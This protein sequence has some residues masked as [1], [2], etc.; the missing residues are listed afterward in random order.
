MNEVQ[1]AEAI[2]ELTAPFFEKGFSFE[3]FHQKGGDSSCVYVFRYKKGKDYFDW[4]E[5]S[6]GNE[7][8]IVVYV[9]GEFRFPSLKKLY[10]KKYRAFAIKHLFK[11]ATLANR[12]ALTASVLLAELTSDK[13]DFFG[14]KL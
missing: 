5:V 8:N 1:S 4:R 3:Y 6:G 14:I 7:I 13:P 9:N 12:R 10:P 2:K 11:R